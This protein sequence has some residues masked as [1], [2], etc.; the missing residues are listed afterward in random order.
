MVKILVLFYLPFNS[1]IIVRIKVVYV[2]YLG[3]ILLY[4][5]CTT[6]LIC[7]NFSLYDSGIKLI[8]LGLCVG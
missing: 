4:P 8:E 5:T 3:Y 2:E 7:T 1:I 6:N